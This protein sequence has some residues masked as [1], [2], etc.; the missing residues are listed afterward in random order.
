MG[1]YSYS[2]LLKLLTLQPQVPV[3]DAIQNQNFQIPVFA[4]TLTYRIS[5]MLLPQQ[6]GS[7][8]GF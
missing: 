1:K 8:H 7:V 5:C 2:E 4:V 3:P 6:S